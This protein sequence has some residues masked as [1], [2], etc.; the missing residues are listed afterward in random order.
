[1]TF[2]RLELIC[3][4]TP[5]KLD[6]DFLD[7][8]DGLINDF[9]LLAPQDPH[10]SLMLS[11]TVSIL[12]AITARQPRESLPLS[13]ARAFL[14]QIIKGTGMSKEHTE[15]LISPSLGILMDIRD[16]ADWH[17]GHQFLGL[18]STAALLD[19]H[20]CSV[21]LALVD[22]ALE[23]WQLAYPAICNLS[24]LALSPLS[25]VREKALGKLSSLVHHQRPALSN[26]STSAVGAHDPSWIV[27]LAT[28]LALTEVYQNASAVHGTEAIGTTALKLLVEA[29][30]RESHELLRKKY[31]AD[32]SAKLRNSLPRNRRVLFLHKYLALA[33][34]ELYAEEQAK[35]MFLK[36]FVD[37]MERAAAARNRALKPMLSKD[38]LARRRSKR[39][40]T[41]L[42]TSAAL[43]PAPAPAPAQY[44][45]LAPHVTGREHVGL[46][47]LADR[48]GEGTLVT[49]P[50]SAQAEGWM[51]EAD[52][53]MDQ[54]I[55]GTL[56]ARLSQLI[57][58][59]EEYVK[60]PATGT[61]EGYRV[62]T[63]AGREEELIE[64]IQ[65]MERPDERPTRA[66]RAQSRT[67]LNKPRTP[68][69]PRAVVVGAAA[70][71]T[72]TAAEVPAG[73]PDEE[74]V[75]PAPLHLTSRTRGPSAWPA[76]YYRTYKPD[77]EAISI[78]F[79]HMPLSGRKV[80]LQRPPPPPTSPPVPRAPEA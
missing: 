40:A 77:L 69:A 13:V 35:T 37:R 8:L 58:Q 54:E 50:P 1:M 39:L 75:D 24:L 72:A 60:R 36:S 29:R 34:A 19:G 49:E 68:H 17:S 55:E 12:F 52:L 74:G 79:P 38:Y 28:I 16:T 7:M 11:N 66:E 76:A 62:G 45:T 10:I 67:R 51:P 44:V 22:G 30:G 27:R 59:A 48:W 9:G 56:R 25:Y 6:V 57:L 64:S 2:L 47:E 73:V 21:Y 23:Q 14:C 20:A 53:D 63:A 5:I 61:T 26:G 42:T 33:M 3:Q 31:L 65:H 4:S 32:P 15:S 46:E 70:T 78:L 71:T 43:A 18:M 80:E 41:S